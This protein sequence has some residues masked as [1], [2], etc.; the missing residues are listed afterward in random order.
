MNRSTNWI[1]RPALLLAALASLA[2]PASARLREDDSMYQDLIEIARQSQV[3]PG[4]NTGSG[5]RPVARPS[6]VPDIFGTGAVL[7]VGN[8]FMKITNYG[9][10]GNG[11]PQLSSDPSCQWPGPSGIEYLSFIGLW[12][13][14]VNPLAS[15]PTAIRRVSETTEFRPPTLDREDRMYR[16]YDGIINGTRFVNDDSDLDPATGD[17]LIDEDFLD[18]RDNDGD[19]SIDEDFGAIGQ[20]VWSC[21]IRDDTQQAIQAAATER[22]VPL[23]LEVRQTAWAYSIPG[24]TDFNVISWEIYNRSGHELDSVF[25]GMRDDM[26]CGPLEK[27]DFYSDDFNFPAYP[28]GDF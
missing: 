17:A 9:F 18:G 12:V 20:M 22:H 3:G 8:L 11:F 24:Y 2:S 6:D 15:D 21:V 5:G 14:G 23:G 26:D 10:V 7:T 19:G 16:A 28:Q 4:Q 13:G 1:V 25:I 27:S